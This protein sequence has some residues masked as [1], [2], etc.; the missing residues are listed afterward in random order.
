MTP[1][2]KKLLVEASTS[3]IGL[4]RGTFAAENQV[5]EVKRHDAEVRT[6]WEP[7]FRALS[8]KLKQVKERNIVFVYHVWRQWV[9]DLFRNYFPTSTFVEVQVT[10]SLLLDRYVNR[11]AERGM[12]LEAAWRD[13]DGPIQMLRERY[14][15][16]YK[17]NEEH[18]KKFVEWRY[19]FYREPWWKQA[20]NT[21]VVQNDNFDGA[22]HLENIINLTT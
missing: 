5:E 20:H 15:P 19:I 8:E 18:F 11:M 17:G 21:F 6:A 16:E 3:V 4:M 22:Q 13:R 2:L 1:Q 12:N 10:R 7:C 9:V 14:G